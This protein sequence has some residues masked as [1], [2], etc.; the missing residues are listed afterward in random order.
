MLCLLQKEQEEKG[1][2]K[3]VILALAKENAKLKEDLARKCSVRT[4]ALPNNP[5]FRNLLAHFMVVA[6]KMQ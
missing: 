5:H 4:F 6:L 2:G 1:A 3:E